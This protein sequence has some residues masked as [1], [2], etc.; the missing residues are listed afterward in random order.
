MCCNICLVRRALLFSKLLL[1]AGTLQ[2]CRQHQHQCCT[3]LLM[4]LQPECSV[5]LCPLLALRWL[6]ASRLSATL[7][8][9]HGCLPRWARGRAP[10]C[11]TASWAASAEGPQPT[12]MI[13]VP[14]TP[15]EIT[16]K[17]KRPSV[18]LVWCGAKADQN[19][20]SMSIIVSCVRKK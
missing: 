15:T 12:E 9:C 5:L 20:P 10:R 2:R 18:L 4:L 14:P 1:S 3:L 6:A 16:V 13:G 11:G 19:A 17:H 8:S 7:P